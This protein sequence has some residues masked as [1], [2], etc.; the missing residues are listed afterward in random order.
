MLKEC[1]H[2]HTKKIKKEFYHRSSKKDGLDYYCKSCRNKYTVGNIFNNKGYCL[3]DGCDKP[4]Y[5][6]MMCRNH[7]AN[8]MYHKKMGTNKVKVGR[9]R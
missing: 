7:Y 4:H 2:C 8:Y 5:A 9:E 6:R 3:E 1:S